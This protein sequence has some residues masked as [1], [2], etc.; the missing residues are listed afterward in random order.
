M[1]DYSGHANPPTNCSTFIYKKRASMYL[2][3]RHVPPTFL[4]TKSIY[5]SQI[6]SGYHS[7]AYRIMDI[8]NTKF[9]P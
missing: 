4:L 8:F 5:S 1:Q 2:L 9:L 6:I 3:L 7:L